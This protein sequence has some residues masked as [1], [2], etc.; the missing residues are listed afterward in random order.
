M[1]YCDEINCGYY[2][3]AEEDDFP[4]CHFD[5]PNGWAPCEYDDYEEEDDDDGD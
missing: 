5:G 1:S 3:K 2:Y 4:C